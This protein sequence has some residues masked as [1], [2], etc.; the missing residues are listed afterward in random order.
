MARTLF[1]SA[2]FVGAAR[3]I[4]A[5]LGPGAV[6]VD[7]VIARAQAPKG[8][9]YHRFASRNA[10]LGQLWLQTVLAYQAGFVAAIE[11][12]DGPGAALHTPSWAR[13]HLEDARVLLL[14][15]RH[16]FVQGEWPGSLQQD[17]AE[18]TRRMEGCLK[19][20]ARQYFGGIRAPDIRRAQFVLLEVPVAAVKSHLQKGERP[21]ALV[22]DL[23]TRTFN[24]IVHGS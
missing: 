8:S 21:P 14:H 1:D 7:A 19:T 5:N 4:A 17:V 24:A 12:G 22:D 18:Q 9:F 20:F 6:T 13:A 15:G 2:A 16:D 23:I 3:D 11:A 10:L